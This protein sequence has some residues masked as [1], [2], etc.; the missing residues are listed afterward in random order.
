MSQPAAQAP[1]YRAVAMQNRCRAVNRL[2]AEDG[3][4]RILENIARL[5]PQVRA[6]LAFHG[7]DLRL[8]VFPEYFLTG[9]P[10]TESVEAWIAKACLDPRGPEYEALGRLAQ[11]AGVFLAGNAYET[12]SHFPGLFFQACFVIGPSGDVVLRYRRL[13]SMYSPTPHDVWSAYLDRYGVEG[14]F[15]VA[16]TALGRFGAIASEEIL[17]PEIARCLAL[18]GA[19]VLIHPTSE[20]YSRRQ[21]AK[22][23]AKLARANENLAYVISANSGGI[24][25]TAV[26]ESSTDGGS[27][28]VDYRGLVLAE[29][30]PGESMTACAEIDLAASRRFRARP[31]MTNLLCRQR[32]EAYN[33]V[34]AEA[35]VYPANTLAGVSFPDR[36][37]FMDAIRESIKR[38][39]ENGVV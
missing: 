29:S 5:G 8:F 13:N 28:I 2:N 17:Y 10:M 24:Q 3:R 26:P 25:D 30:G 9:F 35:S 11:D 20:V 27:K 7:D 36:G 23:V 37:H 31:G 34:F 39:Q 21:T 38:L 19:E 22:D 33:A 15:P 16:D 18:R 14:V 32:F 4:A 6:A 12:D 1:A